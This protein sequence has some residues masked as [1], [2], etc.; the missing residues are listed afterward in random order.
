MIKWGSTTVTVIKWGN[1]T[2]TCVKWGDTVVFPEGYGGGTNY[3][4][5]IKNGM[6]KIFGNNTPVEISGSYTGNNYRDSYIYIEGW[7]SID[8]DIDFTPYTHATVTFYGTTTNSDVAVPS[9][10][11][12]INDN[13]KISNITAISV[14][15]NGTYET[16]EIDL[17]YGY[18]T[19]TSFH[20]LW[21]QVKVYWAMTSTVTLTYKVTYINFY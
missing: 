2:C 4:G 7:Q 18:Y 5:P 20:R 16:R 13:D 14:S 19:S 21:A 12:Y 11:F 15:S 9:I 17:N 3:G 1:T 6:R 8:S 10:V